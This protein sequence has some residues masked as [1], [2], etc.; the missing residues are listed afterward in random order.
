MQQHD[1]DDDP[2][3]LHAW[4]RHENNGRRNEQTRVEG[5]DGALGDGARRQ[6]PPRLV[7]TIDI[8]IIDVVDRISRGRRNCDRGEK[9]PG[10]VSRGRHR[11]SYARRQQRRGDVVRPDDD[12]KRKC[13]MH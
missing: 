11:K 2:C 4:E 6:G 10:P 9:S 13:L 7:D 5:C 8:D 3:R 1:P 12:Y